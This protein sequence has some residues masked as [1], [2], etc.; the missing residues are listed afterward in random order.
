MHDARMIGSRIRSWIAPGK[1]EMATA[2]ALLPR[3]ILIH[4]Q[5]DR[6]RVLRSAMGD[7]GCSAWS[8]AVRQRDEAERRSIVVLRRSQFLLPVRKGSRERILCRGAVG[9]PTI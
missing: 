8:G 3:Y 2:S 9:K 4:L 5:E 7:V 1:S 6:P